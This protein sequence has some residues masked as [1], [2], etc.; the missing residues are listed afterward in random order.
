MKQADC[1][2][3]TISVADEGLEEMCFPVDLHYP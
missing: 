2:F 1:K 3:P